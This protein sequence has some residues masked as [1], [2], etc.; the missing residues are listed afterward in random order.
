MLLLL[1]FLLLV[2]SWLFGKVSFSMCIK[3]GV[4]KVFVFLLLFLFL[5]VL[6]VERV[7]VI[8]EMRE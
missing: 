7:E 2:C 4:K 6:C 8:V 3:Q 5:F 1:D